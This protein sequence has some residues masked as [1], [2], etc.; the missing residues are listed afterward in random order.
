MKAVIQIVLLI[1]V[2]VAQAQSKYHIV[3]DQSFYFSGEQMLITVLKSDASKVEV[4]SLFLGDEKLPLIERNMQMVEGFGTIKI[5]IPKNTKS[6]T[7]E[8]NIHNQYENIGAIPIRI[9]ERSNDDPLKDI[10][11]KDSQMEELVKIDLADTVNTSQQISAIISSINDTDD[12]VLNAFIT[13]R[14]PRLQSFT[15]NSATTQPPREG[16]LIK[17]FLK[18]WEGKILANHSFMMVVPSVNKFYSGQSNEQGFFEIEADVFRSEFYGVFL[19][20]SPQTHEKIQVDLINKSWNSVNNSSRSEMT[21]AK[22]ELVNMVINDAFK[23]FD[24][25]NTNSTEKSDYSKYYDREVRP[26]EYTSESMFQVFN[27][28]VPKVHV[29]GNTFGMYALESTTKLRVPPML[30]VNGIPTYDYDYVLGLEVDEVESI[31][32]IA[33]FKTLRRYFQA[34]NGGI[35]EVNTVNKNL[36][37]PLTGN[38]VMLKGI[39]QPLD[40]EIKISSEE[41]SFSSL[42]L[43]K[44]RLELKQGKPINLAFET[45]LESGFYYFIVAGIAKEGRL[46]YQA[47]PFYI[48]QQKANQ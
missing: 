24:F 32:V 19:S 17:G 21:S 10:L 6:G 47:I 45:S 42:L 15:N 48:S 7:Y 16:V 38:V 13:N 44:P 31:G 3:T 27:D 43:F 29:R 40:E 37:P 23:P 5:P 39:D 46:C 1:A 36:T 30:L 26:A 35:I 33:S 22:R 12:A 28:I 25:D 8:L 4:I 9:N 14:K 41:V 2:Q 20:F 11:A 34:G 18:D